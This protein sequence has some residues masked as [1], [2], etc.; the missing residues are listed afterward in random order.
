MLDM[1][2]V[3]WRIDTREYVPRTDYKSAEEISQVLALSNSTVYFTVPVCNDAV[4]NIEKMVAAAEA[5]EDVPVAI[6]RITEDDLRRYL[7]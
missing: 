7:A 2:V 5:P 4:D 1:H 6:E 3:I